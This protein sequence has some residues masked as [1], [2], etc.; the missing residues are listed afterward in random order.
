MDQFRGFTV[1]G[2]ILVNFLGDFEWFSKNYP[3]LK[4]HNTYFS[5]ADTI[6]PSFHFAVG[7]ALRLV[8]L[9]RIATVGVNKAYFHSIKR[10]LG[11]ILISVV[12]TLSPGQFK[13]WEGLQDAGWWGAVS[14]YFKVDFW[15]TLAIIGVT[16]LWV[17]PVIAGS[18]RARL[19]FLLLSL[20][21]HVVLSYW[22][23]F[24]FMYDRPSVFDAVW[25]PCKDRGLDGGPFGI[26]AWTVP[27]LIGSMAYD[28][29]ASR[30]ARSSFARLLVAGL[31]LGGLGY[32]SSCLSM[33][34]PHGEPGSKDEGSIPVAQS[35]VLPPFLNLHE[36]KPED[37][38][39]EPP[40]V[41]PSE[42]KQRELNY[43]LMGK[44][45]VT[46]PFILCATGYAL[47]MYALFVLL[48][49]VGPLRLGVFRTF[50][51]NPLAAYLIHERVGEA[52]GTFAPK[53]APLEWVL[54][55]FFIYFAITYLFVRYLENHRIYLRM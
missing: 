21:G 18:F 22:F 46:L 2:M 42:D 12:I 35:P 25:G 44:R 4:H 39:A 28:V 40:F 26:L 48:C 55:C 24:D 17:L 47:A 51:Q 11:L 41:Q 20:G 23:N 10:N 29:V 32:L 13:S 1:V 37:L 5:Y 43:W 52:V 6:M 45:V 15:G 54:A 36:L 3:V 50:G 30:T 49:D 9:R 33:L 16:S 27:Q 38:W 7:F 14:S 34:Y 8:L 53:D 19:L 31:V